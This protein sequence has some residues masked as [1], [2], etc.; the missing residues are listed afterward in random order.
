MT[1]ITF[2]VTVR[3]K[4]HPPEHVFGVNKAMFDRIGNDCPA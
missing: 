2:N 3:L 4:T 1:A